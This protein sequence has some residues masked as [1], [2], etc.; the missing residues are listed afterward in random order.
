MSWPTVDSNIIQGN[1]LTISPVAALPRGL[2]WFQCNTPQCSVS[3]NQ[4]ISNALNGN[5]SGVGINF[6]ND[7][8]QAGGRMDSN[9]VTAN[10]I[11]GATRRSILVR[12]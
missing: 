10:Q 9:Q 11:T 1:T 4:V 3:N 12:A 8:G 6:E 7:D 2:I 5:N